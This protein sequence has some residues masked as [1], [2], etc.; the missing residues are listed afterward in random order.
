[1][2]DTT[3]TNFGLVKPEVGASED[4]WGTKINAD[5]DSLDTL[6]GNGSPMKIDT[7][8]DRVGI[9]TATPTTAL[10][11]NGDLTIADKIIHSGDTNTS[12]RFP[13]ADTVTVETNGTERMRVDSSGNVGIGTTTPTSKLQVVGTS[14]SP[15]ARLGTLAG[16]FE[17]NAYDA[18]AVYCVVGGNNHIA[19]VFGTQSNTPTMFFT[20]NTERMRI[21]AA[22][23][24]GIGTSSPT[25]TLTVNGTIGGTIVATQAEAEAGTANNKLMT[26][27]R[28]AQTIPAKLNAT[29]SAPLYACRAWVNFNGTGTVAIRASGNVSSITDNGT[30][31]YTVNFTTAMPD[32]NYSAVA[33]TNVAAAGTDARVSVFTTTSFKIIVVNNTSQADGDPV[34]AAVFR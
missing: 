24:V 10:E 6:L 20:N 34:C 13:A 18:D 28:T 23:N 19:A 7:V 2:A 33:A 1:M 29:G 17:I 11:V 12:I 32:A 5:L 14:G 25:Q 3:T 26:P 16:Y 9:N 21:T 31:D 30:G 4:T 27:E 8:N 15:Q 22:G